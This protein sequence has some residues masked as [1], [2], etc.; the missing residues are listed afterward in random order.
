VHSKTGKTQVFFQGARLNAGSRKIEHRRIILEIMGSSFHDFRQ[1]YPIFEERCSMEKLNAKTTWRRVPKRTSGTKPNRLHVIP[2]EV[3]ERLR[4][5]AIGCFIRL[6]CQCP[7]VAFESRI[8]ELIRLGTT[9][10][11]LG[12]RLYA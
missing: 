8:V 5:I 4:Q 12:P 7:G 10:R 2:T 1:A 9:V 6:P 11:R 3:G